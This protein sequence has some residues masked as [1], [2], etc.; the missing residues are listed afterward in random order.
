MWHVNL[1]MALFLIYTVL[2]VKIYHFKKVYVIFFFL[3]LFEVPQEIKGF[4]EQ[5]HIF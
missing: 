1:Y 2:F 4:P 3:F 5:I